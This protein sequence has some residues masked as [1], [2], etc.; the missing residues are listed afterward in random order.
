M[1]SPGLKS[2]N[3]QA[4]KR[5]KKKKTKQKWSHLLY[6]ASG[7]QPQPWING[8]EISPRS[9]LKGKPPRWSYSFF[10]S[11]NV[12]CMLESMLLLT[13]R[14]KVKTFRASC[15]LIVR[16]GGTVAF[17][18]SWDRKLGRLVWEVVGS[19]WLKQLCTWPGRTSFWEGSDSTLIPKGARI[20]PHTLY[21]ET[22]ALTPFWS[23]SPNILV[24]HSIGQ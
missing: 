16:I 6:L 1:H 23:P 20:S 21:E 14:H 2:E 13:S 19:N 7:I 11:P 12:F 9:R 24:R 5:K 10:I 15:G 22:N 4:Q 3:V 18:D 17:W 8:A